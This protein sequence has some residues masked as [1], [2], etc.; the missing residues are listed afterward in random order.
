MSKHLVR[1]DYLLDNFAH[2]SVARGGGRYSGRTTP[3]PPALK[4]HFSADYSSANILNINQ[5][6]SY[7]ATDLCR[8]KM[9]VY[10][11]V[12]RRYS[13]EAAKHII[14]LF[15]PSGRHTILVFPH[16]TL[17]SNGDPPPPNGSAECKG[18]E[19]RT[20]IANRSRVS[21]RR[22]HLGL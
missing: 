21:I 18:Y 8:G 10:L 9:S 4:G 17:R 12:T 15:L 16:Q 5:G 22:G 11:S 3:S 20:A 13:V 7:T 19:T 14:N 6:F 1:Y 2:R